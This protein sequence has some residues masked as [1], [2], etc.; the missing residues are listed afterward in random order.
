MSSS[1]NSSIHFLL[2]K[3]LIVVSEVFRSEIYFV[4]S[5]SCN[6]AVQ[7]NSSVAFPLLLYF[8]AAGLSHFLTANFKSVK[9]NRLFSVSK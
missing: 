4:S 3:F 8:A 1:L 2:C 9:K 6:L 5:G 7:R